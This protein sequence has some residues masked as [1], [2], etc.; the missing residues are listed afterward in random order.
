MSQFL[1]RTRIA[2][3]IFATS[4]ALSS[5]GAYA[6]DA[7]TGS[8]SGTVTDSTGA[9]IK[10]ATITLINTDRNHVERTLTTNGAGFYTATGLPLGTY[11]VKISDQGFKTN[12]VTTLAL[13]VGDALTVNRALSAGDASETVT[14]TADEALV[15]LQDATSAGLINAEQM[16]EMPLVTRN[17]ETLLNL[18]PGVAFGGA[19]DDL[20]RGPAGLSGA[21]STVAFSVN[22]GRTT[23]NGWTI[24]GADN[25]DRGANLTLYVYPSPDSISE[26]KTLRGQY[27]AEYG[28]NASGQVDVVTKS[29]TNKLHGSAYDYIRNDALDANGYANDFLGTHIGAYRYN[30][31]GFSVG[32]PVEIPKVYHGK[33]KT[34]FFVSEEWQRIIQNLP[35]TS[36][37]VPQASERAGDFSQS[38]YKNSAGQWTTG[39]ITVCTAYTTNPATQVNTCTATGTQ[40]TNISPTAQQYLKDIYSKIPVPDVTYNIAHNLDPHTILSSFKNTFNNLDSVVRIDQ[41]FGQKIK[42]FYR[43]VHDTFPEIL[44]QGQFTTVP[45]PGANTTVATNPGTQHLAKGQY[46]FSPTALLNVGYAFSNGN[47]VSTPSGFL[48]SSKSPDVNP[49]LVYANTV[50]VVP[51]VSVSGMTSLAGS[52]AYTDHGTNHQ[53]FGDFTKILHNNTIIAGF[54]YNHYQK[55]ENNTTG[56][57]GAFS[58]ATDAAFTN[59]PSNTAAGATEAQAYANFLT[60]NANGG[61]SQLSRD[62][63]TD[64]KGALY[65]AFVQDNW[66][67]TKHLT[68]NAGVRYAYYGQPWDANLLLSN[69]DPSQY[70]ASKAPTI[71]TTGLIC[72]TGTCSQ[73]NSNAGQSTTPNPAADYAGIN[74]INGLI[75]NGPNA[76]NNNQASQFG[77]KVGNAQ[78]T[79]FAPRFGFALDVFGDGKT[80]LRG[81]YGWAFDDAEVSYYETTVFNNPPAVATYSVGQTSFDSPAGGATTALSTTPGRI[82]AV[83]IDYK[84]PYVQ[85][86]SLDVQQQIT[87]T[88]MLDVGYFG[89]HG[90]HLLGA[91]NENQP[92]PGSWVGKV[93]PANSGSA[94][95]DPDTNAQSF[96]NS[97]CDRVLNQIKPY[98]GY[99]SVDSLRTIF[100]SNYNALQAKVTK[101]FKGKTYIDANYTWSRDLTNAQ[102]D[103]SGFDENI[104]N[105][106]GDYG[107]AAVDRTNILSIDGVYELPW[108][109][110]Q[111]GLVGHLVG[112]WEISGIYAID[113]GLPLTVSASSA[114][115][116]NYNLPGGAASVFNGR[117]NTGYITDNAGLGALGNTNAG[118]RLN[119][120][121]DPNQGY[122]TK[123]HNKGYNALWFYS[124]AFAAAPPSQTN[125]A[126]TA[127]RGTIQGPGFNRLDL[128]VH[129]NFRLYDRLTFQF[130]AEAF[131]AV[132]HTNVQSINTAAGSTGTFGEVTGYRDARILQFAGRIEF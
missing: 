17:Y 57:Q 35:A 51:T 21:S 48:G 85:Q 42:I 86:Y 78:K 59:V 115:S 37:L 27:S 111:K 130:R 73:A 110:D 68:I 6:Q 16:N 5:P 13:H 2:A 116:P 72:F 100:S 52:L 41:E 105:V 123:I 75:Y 50:G 36:A 32:G 61:F 54:S 107:R 112:G 131:N 58:F 84:T 121:G 83:P 4:L 66:K 109:R 129:R 26:F 18:Q 97:T 45:I 69:F 99:F 87:P 10:G 98:L 25:L 46:I 33:D 63:V 106:N 65:E 119:Q 93:L 79:N 81:G 56:T 44:P 125:I 103:Y 9:I 31:Y 76:N 132:N 23:S 39:P 15:N 49:S 60:G 70:S 71:A 89:D 22:G 94:C 64:I 124:G 95:I 34:F 82:Q 102:A 47:I 74:Y 7:T 108:Y 118:L 77:N 127:K 113:S 40:V 128:G 126:P 53:V 43:Y 55:L 104:Y 101:R 24:D 114:Y 3:C 8:I 30:V 96:L 12:T 90:T 29:G 80:S 91:L 117:T 62:P 28:R 20:T 19:T 88:L 11:S 67:A 120:L 38:G 1:S 92:V 122:G 14:V